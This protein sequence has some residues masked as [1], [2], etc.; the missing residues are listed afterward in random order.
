MMLGWLL[1]G[2]LSLRRLQAHDLLN[3]QAHL[4]HATCQPAMCAMSYTH[5]RWLRHKYMTCKSKWQYSG[6]QVLC[7]LLGEANT[8][9]TTA[10]DAQVQAVT[11]NMTWGTS[12]NIIRRAEGKLHCSDNS[13][14]RRSHID[15]IGD[16]VAQHR[17]DLHRCREGV[18]AAVSQPVVV[19]CLGHGLVDTI[20]LNTYSSCWH[21]AG[22][23]G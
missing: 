20:H 10:D 5:S 3:R 9:C 22:K 13:T 14:R 23:N 21:P 1:L 2:W 11:C 19:Y 8:V 15:N 6:M 17:C 4:P 12:N 7:M 16:C 18:G